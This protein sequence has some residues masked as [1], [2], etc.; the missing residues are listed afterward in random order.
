MTLVPV[1]S[2]GKTQ[3]SDDIAITRNEVVIA[4]TI[5]C[6]SSVCSYFNFLHFII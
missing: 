2:F 4:V 3:S 6:N 5:F 1:L